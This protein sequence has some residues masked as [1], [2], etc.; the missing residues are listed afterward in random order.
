[1]SARPSISVILPV[2]D[3]ARYL[4]AA[5]RSIELQTVPPDEI[6]V[7][8]HASKDASAEIARRHRGVRVIEWPTG[9]HSDAINAG[10]LASSGEL[11]AFLAAD[12]EWTP[13]KLEAQT[14][15]LAAPPRVDACV[16]L[17][18]H[19]ADGAAGPLPSLRAELLERALPARLPETLLV[20]RA[21][22][23]RVG[24][25]RSECG[26]S[27]DF[28]WFLRAA[29][30]AVEIAVVPEVVLIKRLHADAQTQTSPT[31][32]SGILRAVHESVQRKRA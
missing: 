30:M 15:R 8:D 22:W 18:E 13:R 20:P 32:H 16:G 27:F 25:F 11:L 2:R 14:A 19:V 10:V 7:V 3:G 28:D 17:V 23:E 31:T 6:I 26:T 9:S 21:V 12:D 5:L 29:D 24:R 4:D 1:M